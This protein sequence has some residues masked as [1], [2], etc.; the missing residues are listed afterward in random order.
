[1]AEKDTKDA[2]A[3]VMK[4]LRRFQEEKE[5]DLRRYMVG[6]LRVARR[7]CREYDAYTSPQMEFAQCH[8]DWARRNQASWEEAKAEVQNIQPHVDE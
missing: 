3:G 1:V 6:C 4:D 2:S 5:N 7:S 8:I